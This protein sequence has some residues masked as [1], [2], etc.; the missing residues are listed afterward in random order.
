V[1]YVESLG[2]LRMRAFQLEDLNAK[3]HFEYPVV[4]GK[5]ILIW[6]LKK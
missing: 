3:E 2:L 1:G 5:M 6:T 4:V